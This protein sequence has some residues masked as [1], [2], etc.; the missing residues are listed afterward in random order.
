MTVLKKEYIIHETG[1]SWQSSS[2]LLIETFKT[3]GYEVVS[4]YNTVVVLDKEDNIYCHGEY[5]YRD[6]VNYMLVDEAQF[7]NEQQVKQLSDITVILNIPVICYG[8]RLDFQAKG[9]PGST[10]L[11]EIA[12]K[13]EE[14]KTA[15]SVALDKVMEK[16]GVLS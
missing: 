4:D 10:R 13:L 3:E 5:L 1:Y 12:H 2:F 16:R 9:F 7:L 6:R 8:L 15:L 14:M 11:L